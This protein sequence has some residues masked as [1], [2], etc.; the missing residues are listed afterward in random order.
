MRKSLKKIYRIILI[1]MFVLIL[2]ITLFICLNLANVYYKKIPSVDTVPIYVEMSQTTEPHSTEDNVLITEQEQTELIHLKESD[3]EQEKDMLATEVIESEVIEPEVIPSKVDVLFI[4]DSRTVGLANYAS[5]EN[6][7][8]FSTIGMSVYNVWERQVSVP[9]IGKVNLKELLDY[10][11][12]DIVYIMLGINELG[13]A[14]EKTIECYETLVESVMQSQSDAIIILMANIHVT[15]ERSET[16]KYINNL[17]IN[18]FNDA[19]MELVDN[20]TIFYLDANGLFDDTNGNLAEEKSS[21]N[22]HL[23]A[24]YYIQWADWLEVKTTEIILQTKGEKG[25]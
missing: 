19:T 15:A 11:Q 17:A 12:Y 16:D 3:A 7:N 14:F 13:Y 6:A 20:K 5:I 24:K 18:Q 10:K 22:A 2:I 21:D 4:G 23:K 1:F 8:F 9:E 25:D